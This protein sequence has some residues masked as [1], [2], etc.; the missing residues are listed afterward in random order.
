MRKSSV[1]SAL[2]YLGI[3]AIAGTGFF[4]GTLAGN[5]SMVERAGGSIWVFLLLSIILMP[6]VIPRIKN[7]YIE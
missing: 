5:Y 1:V 4:F 6:I 2:I 7:K 3:P